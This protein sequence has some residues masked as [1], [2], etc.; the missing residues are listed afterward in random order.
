M[1]APEAAV[2][3]SFEQALRQ[4]EERVQKLESGDLPLDDAL[5]LFEEGVSLVRQC[6]ERLDAADARI[7][8]LSRGPDGTPREGPSQD[9]NGE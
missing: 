7:Q 2:E 5:R 6:H 1:S 8:V 9:R 4:L 3:L